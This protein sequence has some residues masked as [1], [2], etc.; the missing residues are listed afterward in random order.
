M[1]MKRILDSSLGLLRFFLLI[2]GGSF[3][4]LV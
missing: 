2:A 1:F 3:G 4:L